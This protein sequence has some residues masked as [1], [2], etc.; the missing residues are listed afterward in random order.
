M[1]PTIYTYIIASNF[2]LVYINIL[3]PFFNILKHIIIYTMKSY[4]DLQNIFYNNIYKF[5]KL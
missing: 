1:F 2:N 4:I 3:E 5:T